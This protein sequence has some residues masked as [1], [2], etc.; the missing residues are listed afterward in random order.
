MTVY[1]GKNPVGVGRIVEKKVAKEKYGATVD[2]F[3]GDVDANGN[4]VYSESSTHASINLNGVKSVPDKAFYYKFNSNKNV[5][6]FIANDLVSVG[7]ES[8]AYCFANSNISEVHID[9]IEE[10]TEIKAFDGFCNYANKLQNVTF[11]KLKRISANQVFQNAFSSTESLVFDNTFPEL[12]EISG[13]TVF[14]GWKKLNDNEVFTLS[15]VKKITNT[16]TSK[17][18][19]TFGTAYRKGLVWNLPSATELTGYIWNI[20]ASDAGEIHFAAANQAAIEACD[21]YAN[22]WGFAGATIYFDL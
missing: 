19:S 10:I 11:L 15:K 12:E 9:N 18:S 17:Y 1:L 6:S 14:S 20:N 7:E 22:K 2:N 16:A 13:Q 21:G 4:Y 8:F 5:N 3:L